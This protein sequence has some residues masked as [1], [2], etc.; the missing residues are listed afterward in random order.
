MIGRRAFISGLLGGVLATP[1]SVRPQP[2]SKPPVLGVLVTDAAHN[3]SLPLLLQGLRDLG[4]IDGKNIVVEIRSADGKA[5]RFPLLAKELVQL[6]PD[7]V[8]ATG[9]AAIKAARGATTTI[10]IVALD[11][12]SDPVE[13]G[14]A[15][16]LAHPAGNVT[17]LFLNLPSLTGKWLELITQVIPD[18]RHVTIL[19]DPSTGSAQLN[20]AKEVAQRLPIDLSII[21]FRGATELESALP[22]ELDT[23]S[24]AIV[25]LSSPAINVESKSIAALTTKHRLAA[26][27]PF[28]EFADA[29]GLMSYG[30]KFDDF[31][32]RAA[33][34]VDRIIKGANAGDVPIEQPTKFELVVN[35]KT[36]KALGVVIPQSVLVRADDIIE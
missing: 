6:K 22:P 14:W 32:G 29:G 1:F 30:P 15:R 3:T 27:S 2:T 28:R 13:A 17:G 19:W 35:L 12:E 20:A 16:S 36:A 21:K 23:R 34:F 4:Y 26:I 11:L 24:H 18:A 33:L 8:Y 9:P 7:V 25:M 5:E 31:R 10:S